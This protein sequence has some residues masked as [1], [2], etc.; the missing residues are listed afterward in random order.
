MHNIFTILRVFFVHFAG[1]V[2]SAACRFQNLPALPIY[3]RRFFECFNHFSFPR[4]PLYRTCAYA[5]IAKAR[6]HPF[7]P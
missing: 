4:T 7:S 3:T 2:A 1:T 6:L 5:R